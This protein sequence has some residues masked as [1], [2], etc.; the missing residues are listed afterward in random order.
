MSYNKYTPTVE[1]VKTPTTPTNTYIERQAPPPV[2][3]QTAEEVR[4]PSLNKYSSPVFNLKDRKP[5]IENTDSTENKKQEFGL[6]YTPKKFTPSKE[7]LARYE[8]NQKPA[9]SFNKYVAPLSRNNNETGL[10]KVNRSVSMR[11]RPTYETN[12]TAVAE[13]SINYL[14]NRTSSENSSVTGLRSTDNGLRPSGGYNRS[15]LGN[16]SYTGLNRVGASAE[17]IREEN[18]VSG[19]QVIENIFR[20]TVKVQ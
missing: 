17:K 15:G 5:S 1:T 11:V 14:K 16:N 8:P 3:K 18:Q 6:S 10:N 2:E 19:T 20:L 9:A 4:R 12:K 7:L 13:P